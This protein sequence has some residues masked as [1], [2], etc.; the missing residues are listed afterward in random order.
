MKNIMFCLLAAVT[1]VVALLCGCGGSFVFPATAQEEYARIYADGNKTFDYASVTCYTVTQ[2]VSVDLPSLRDMTYS[3]GKRVYPT[4]AQRTYRFDSRDKEGIKSC[5]TR[6]LVSYPSA[7]KNSKPEYK[8]ERQTYYR[9]SLCYPL[10]NSDG[11]QRDV[12]VEKAATFGGYSEYLADSR[13]FDSKMQK[14]VVY[15]LELF[16]SFTGGVADDGKTY[17]MVGAVSADK[18]GEFFELFAAEYSFIEWFVQSEGGDSSSRIYT[19]FLSPAD[20]ESVT[21]SVAS[22]KNGLTGVSVTVTG[23][24][25]SNPL[26]DLEI[27]EKVTVTAT[28]VYSSAEF[29]ANAVPAPKFK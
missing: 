6:K 29:A 25:S 17:N 5:E 28:T 26:L 14:R 20:F 24:A 13:S 10:M 19:N 16:S 18:Y 11:N 9:G 7:S 4:T 22:D 23:L 8:Y 21:V 2:S 12:A 15:P 1:A 3:D 27:G